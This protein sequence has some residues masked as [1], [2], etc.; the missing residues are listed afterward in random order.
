MSSRK[1]AF[2]LFSIIT[3]LVIGG[4]T[5]QAR[6]KAK[7]SDLAT[8]SVVHAIPTGYGADIVDVY[9]NGTLVID[10]AVPGAIKSFT[11]PKGNMLIQVYANGVVPGPTTTALLSS[12]NVYL[13]IGNNVSFV[14]HLTSDE[15]VTD[16]IEFQDG[17][18][19]HGFEY[20]IKANQPI[21]AFND[22]CDE[23]RAKKGLRFHYIYHGVSIQ[24]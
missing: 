7:A 8:Y 6:T 18:I 16:A 9:A 11:V 13:S 23:R 4:Q 19:G 1:R 15:I 22:H 21:L 17:S 10:N 12:S 5:S 24:L 14:A 2:L 20:L 3:V